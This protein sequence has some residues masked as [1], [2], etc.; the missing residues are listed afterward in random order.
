MTDQPDAVW[1][2]VGNLLARPIPPFHHEVLDE[3]LNIWF[4]WTIDTS[5]ADQESS[6]HIEWGVGDIIGYGI[7]KDTVL[8]KD[9]VRDGDG[10]PVEFRVGVDGLNHFGGGEGFD[11][12]GRKGRRGISLNCNNRD[13]E[14]DG[15]SP[16]SRRGWG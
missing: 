2:S 3:G 4:Q 10:R 5:I 16:H 12:F 14:T 8:L 6:A 7:V 9:V 11:R 1:H 13:V 15:D